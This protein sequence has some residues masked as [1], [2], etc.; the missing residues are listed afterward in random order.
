MII[1]EDWRPSGEYVLR[2]IKL[3]TPKT[4]AIIPDIEKIFIVRPTTVIRRR[5]SGLERFSTI[6]VAHR[7]LDP[8]T[9]VFLLPYG[10]NG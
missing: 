9:C 3:Q 5:K 8:L 6:P 2:S 10:T 7:S 1:Q 4:A